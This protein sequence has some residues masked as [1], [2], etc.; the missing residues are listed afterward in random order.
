LVSAQLSKDRSAL[1]RLSVLE[2]H[3]KVKVHVECSVSSFYN[4]S[5]TAYYRPLTLS[6][7]NGKNQVLMELLWNLR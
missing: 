1:R 3:I 4:F 6:G 2:K 7:D 5:E